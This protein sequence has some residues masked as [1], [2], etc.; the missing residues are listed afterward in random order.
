MAINV[1]EIYRKGVD[2][3]LDLPNTYLAHWAPNSPCDLGDVGQSGEDGW[4]VQQSAANS[5][6]GDLGTPRT[7]TPAPFK[8]TDGGSIELR[9]AL[10]GSTDAAFSFIGAAAAGITLKFEKASSLLV[11]APDA[12][13][14]E[15]DDDRGIAKK[16]LDALQAEELDYGDQVIVGVYRAS[17]FVILVSAESGATADIT[18][19]ATIRQGV[20]NVADVE[21]ELGLVNARSVG[22]QTDSSRAGPIVLGHRAL[23]IADVGI[24]VRRPAIVTAEQ[25]APEPEYD[26]I[27]PLQREHARR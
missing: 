15:I 2:R 22:Y 5:P 12:A 24:I 3:H 7:G 4:G 23:E 9:A 20:I 14:S 8:F 18:T 19:N 26:V 21:G 1:Q 25:I 13:Y 17:S 6:L 27:L 16:M 11:A 10:K